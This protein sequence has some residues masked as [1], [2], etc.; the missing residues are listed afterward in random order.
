MSVSAS[1]VFAAWKQLS[2]STLPFPRAME[3]GSLSHSRKARAVFCQ[4]PLVSCL[5]LVAKGTENTGINLSVL[6]VPC[7]RGACSGNL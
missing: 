7:Q 5:V 3:C 2:L 6:P 1:C 4:V